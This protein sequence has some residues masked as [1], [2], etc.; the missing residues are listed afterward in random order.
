LNRQRPETRKACVVI[1]SWDD[2]SILDN[3]LSKLLNRYQINGTFYVPQ[4]C[5]PLDLID[6][7]ELKKLA[8]DFEIGAHTLTHR[9][10]DTLSPAEAKGE[11]LGGKEYLSA[12]LDQEIELFAYPEG[13]Y[14]SETIDLVKEC[15]FVAAR[16][17]QCFRI[18]RPLSPYTL[19]TTLQVYPNSLGKATGNIIRGRAFAHLAGISVLLRNV[20]K[21]WIDLAKAYFDY[22]HQYGG[23]FHLWG[24]SWE[25]ERLRLWDELEDL[26]AYTRIFRGV[27]YMTTGE[28]LRTLQTR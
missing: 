9:R 4:R 11:I 26:L 24:H 10:L 17:T 28:F 25:I 23:M 15:G 6:E 8:R 13:K 2:G 5:D 7:N 21:P 27:S 22:V 16:T 20:G 1:T 14:T 12:I 18:G 3:E 19:W